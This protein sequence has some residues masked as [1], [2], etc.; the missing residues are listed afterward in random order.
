MNKK[1]ITILV[2]GM[3]SAIGAVYA[4]DWNVGS[5]TDTAKIVGSGT[6]NATL[7]VDVASPTVISGVTS[8]AATTVTATTANATDA[9]IAGALTCDAT[10]LSVTNAQIVTLTKSVY[11][12]TGIGG[13]DDTTNTV[14]LANVAP[15]MVGA[16]ITLIVNSASSNLITIA[17]S[18]PGYLSAAFLGDN[19]D[20]IELYVVAT[21]RLVETSKSNN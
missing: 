10:S 6:G 2:V 20:T 13:A 11:N 8:V 18:A 17:D 19:N 7:T 21:N 9:N 14:V 3:I 4:T 15:A 16:K 5:G 12:L 1:L